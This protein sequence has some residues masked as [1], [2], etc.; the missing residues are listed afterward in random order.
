MWYRF[1]VHTS[2]SWA[3]RAVAPPECGNF[4]YHFAFAAHHARSSLA[5]LHVK[6]APKDDTQDFSSRCY[7][8]LVQTST[9]WAARAV[10]PPECGYFAYFFRII[11]RVPH[12]TQ[13]HP[14]LVGT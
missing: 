11:S 6:L 8:F 9:L 10:V 12:T 2:T 1:L 3:V 4:A 14:W 5:R 7:R 13:A